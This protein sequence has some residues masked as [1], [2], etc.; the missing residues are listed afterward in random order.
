MT[1]T[2]YTS[3]AYRVRRRLQEL[4]RQEILQM[5]SSP[6]DFEAEVAAMLRALGGGAV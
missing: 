4:I 2:A 5:V 6:E 1:V 3:L